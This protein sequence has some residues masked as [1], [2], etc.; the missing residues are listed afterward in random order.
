VRPFLQGVP[1]ADS[2]RVQLL[3]ETGHLPVYYFP[4]ED[5]RLDLAVNDAR[6]THCPY[7][8]DATYHDIQVGERR[9][10]EAAWSYPAAL[11]VAPAAL[12]G[13]VAFYWSKMDAW[14]E[15]DDEVFVHARDPYHRVD[16]LRSSRHVEVI[17]GGTVVAETNRPT[18]LFET[19]LPPRY[20]LPKQ[21]ARLDLLHRSA[22]TSRCPYK[23]EATYYSVATSARIVEDVAWCYEHPMPESLKVEGLLCFFDERVG[24]VVVDGDVQERPRTAWA[25]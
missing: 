3:F 17:V 14:F 18:L 5:V 11:S 20:Y 7:K 24:Q 19:G 2:R 6:R 9:V 22:T 12:A 15:E 23:G 8:G 4:L 16:V 10:E 25:R 1:V 13:L 21:N